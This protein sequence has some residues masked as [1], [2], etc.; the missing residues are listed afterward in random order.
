[1]RCSGHSEAR[2]LR[3]A[4]GGYDERYFAFYEDVD[5]N[6][7]ARIAGWSFALEP[8]AVAWHR[9]RRAWR[10][11]FERPLAQNARLQARNRLATQLKFVPP[12]SAFRMLAV[13]A[14]AL[15]RAAREGRL[16]ET[17]AGKLAVARW[18]PA[19]RSERRELRSSGDLELARR[20]L[21]RVSAG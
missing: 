11:G 6:V 13:E 17:A 20:W 15:G 18:L 14:G 3:G 8:R 4:L 10:Q 5:L 21:G 16:R 12:R 1:M 2:C 19:L 7:R 9:G